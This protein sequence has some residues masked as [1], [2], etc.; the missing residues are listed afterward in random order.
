MFRKNI[1][2]NKSLNLLLKSP[3]KKSKNNEKS[4]EEII[5]QNNNINGNYRTIYFFEDDIGDKENISYYGNNLKHFNFKDFENNDN[6]INI[7]KR[8]ITNN[9]NYTINEKDL[10]LKEEDIKAKEENINKEEEIEKNYSNDT[11]LEKH[12]FINNSY[13]IINES[14]FNNKSIVTIYLIPNDNL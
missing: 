5:V 6:Y 10:S 2:N 3:K 8:K 4:N 13:K 12:K 1:V 9:N 14:K 11:K 7:N